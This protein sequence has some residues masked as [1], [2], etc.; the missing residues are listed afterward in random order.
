MTIVLTGQRRC[1][2]QV[3]S[4]PLAGCRVEL[5]V[6]SAAARVDLLPPAVVA[7]LIITA[8]KLARH[9]SQ[10]RCEHCGHAW[11][12]EVRRQADLALGSL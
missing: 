4:Q 8:R 11:P 9:T 7:V 5:P 1:V 12:A 6:A 10:E 2:P 3:E